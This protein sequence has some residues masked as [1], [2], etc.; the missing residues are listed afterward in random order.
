VCTRSWRRILGRCGSGNQKP[1]R[2]SAAKPQPKATGTDNA[3]G[4]EIRERDAEGR[5]FAA[6]VWDVWRP[7]A[8][9]DVGDL[10]PHYYERCQA[11]A[12]EFLV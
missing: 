9:L 6:A 4:A 8:A 1:Q 3:E 2:R 5:G 11:D 10:S 12:A 7:V